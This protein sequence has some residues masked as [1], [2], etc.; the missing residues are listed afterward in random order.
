MDSEFAE[1]WIKSRSGLEQL[2][3]FTVKLLTKC[4]ENFQTYFQLISRIAFMD[5]GLGFVFQ[6]IFS[7]YKQEV[8]FYWGIFVDPVLKKI[9]IYVVTTYSALLY[10]WPTSLSWLDV[11]KVR[12]HWWTDWVTRWH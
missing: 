1:T 12:S 5:L 7:L 4:H 9:P 3:S 8:K 11:D 10:A 6:I 2:T